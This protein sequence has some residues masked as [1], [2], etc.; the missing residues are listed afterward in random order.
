MVYSSPAV[1]NGVVYIGAATF[2]DGSGAHTYGGVYALNAANGNK[3]W[4]Y[5][6]SSYIHSSPAVVGGGCNNCLMQRQAI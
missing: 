6:T 3:I 5:T 1:V 4:N 2:T